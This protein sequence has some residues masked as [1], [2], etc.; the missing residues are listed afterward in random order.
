M[1]D[2]DEEK[3]RLVASS[4]REDRD[5]VVTYNEDDRTFIDLE[6]YIREKYKGFSQTSLEYGSKNKGILLL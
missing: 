5:G 3:I 2:E 6:M 4:A 1:G